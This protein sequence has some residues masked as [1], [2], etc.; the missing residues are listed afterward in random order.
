M[1][2]VLHLLSTNRFSGAENVACQII[3]MFSDLPEYDMAYCSPDGPIADAVKSKGICFLPMDR[4]SLCEI[5]RVI[6][7]Y[8]PDI[9]H[10]H[11]IRASLLASLCCKQKRIL[12][13]MHVNHENM[14]KPTLKAFLYGISVPRYVH[15][16]WVS[17]SALKDYLFK[18]ACRNKSTVLRN[19]ICIDELFLRMQE[20]NQSYDYDIV[21]VGRITYQ[22][23]PERLIRV[24]SRCVKIM[25]DIR[26]AIVGDGE[27]REHAEQI[28]RNSGLEHN[29]SFL[30]SMSNP[31]KLMHDAKIML[32]TSRF[33]GTPMCALEAMALGV[34]IVST[35]TDG[36]CNLVEDGV[37]GFLS[38]NDDVLVQR[39]LEIITN[40]E[41]R[42]ALSRASMEKSRALNDIDIY[43]ER[44]KDV[45]ERQ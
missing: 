18:Q 33:E 4:L 35:P 16:F 14:K 25:P 6:A 40:P 22:K 44:L 13:H 24:M 8:K 32:M 19:V 12:S 26:C 1:P 38:D 39:L 10:A 20:D 37:T 31:L 34:P 11:D 42:D 45:Y 15:I 29:I 21:F 17:D 41:K 30:G 36:M 7:A 2:R 23:H 27:L 28:V 9:I 5:K 3:R 43:C